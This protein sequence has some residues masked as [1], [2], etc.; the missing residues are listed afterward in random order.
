MMTWSQVLPSSASAGSSAAHCLSFFSH[1]RPGLVGLNLLGPDP[2]DLA[3]VEVFGMLAEATGEAQDG[4][5]AD[6]T[7]PCRGPAATAIGEMLG[8]G[9][10][11]CLRRAQAEQGRV[12]TLGEVR[13][14]GDAV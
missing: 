13:T 5:E 1:K 12:G 4:V 10:Q 8:D 6:L 14:T 2:A 11:G 7:E 9:H 3:I